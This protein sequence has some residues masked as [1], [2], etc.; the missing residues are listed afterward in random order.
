MVQI[1]T[2]TIRGIVIDAKTRETLP[3]AN[4]VLVNENT[5]TISDMEGRFVLQN[6]PV[7]RYNLRISC[8][9]YTSIIIPE[10]LVGSGREVVLEKGWKLRLPNRRKFWLSHPYERINREIVW[11]A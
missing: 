10:L 7:G 3:A 6:I 9:G 1:P 8:I 4:I 5:G 11:Q 2:Q